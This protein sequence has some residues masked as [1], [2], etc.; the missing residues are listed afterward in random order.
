MNLE[1]DFTRRI[2][3]NQESN[4]I[5]QANKVKI[6]RQCRVVLDAF[7]RG[8]RLTVIEAAIK[9][10]VGDLRRRVKDLRDKGFEIKDEMLPGGYKK[11]FLI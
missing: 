10:G 9:Y 1:F 11:Y 4:R 5:L 8:E 2:E 6:N 7:Q 3:N